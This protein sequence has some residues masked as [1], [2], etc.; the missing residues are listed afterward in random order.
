MITI[1][2]SE[3]EATFSP[4]GQRN[5]QTDIKPNTAYEDVALLDISEWKEQYPGE[6]PDEKSHDI[7][8]WGYWT[9]DFTYEPPCQEWREERR[10]MLRDE[11]EYD[12][13]IFFKLLD[14]YQKRVVSDRVIEL[15]TEMLDTALVQLGN[16][17]RKEYFSNPDIQSLMELL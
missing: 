6:D 7:L 13:K 11:A 10:Q 1:C 3:G 8:D 17:G 15:L 14:K 5:Y 9:S 16:A 12:P 4:F 2:G